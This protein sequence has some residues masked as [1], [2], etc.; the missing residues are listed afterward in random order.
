[1]SH[2]VHITS[3]MSVDTCMQYDDDNL[4]KVVKEIM[5]RAP[6]ITGSE[7]DASV[8]IN[9][10]NGYTCSTNMDCE[11]CEYGNTRKSLEKGSFQCNTPD[12]YRCPDREYQTCVVISIQG[13]LRDRLPSQTQKEFSEFYK[14]IEDRFIVR[15][16]SLNIEGE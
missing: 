11:H 6:K 7:E 12:G 16:Y 2:W 3:C 9:I 10:Q 13:D 5:K 8:Y 4:L 1:M 15:D 14:F